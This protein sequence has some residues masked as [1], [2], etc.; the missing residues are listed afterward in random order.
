MLNAQGILI[1]NNH[2]LMV[3]Q[4][5]K[6]GDI[7]WTFPGGGIEAGETPEQACIRELRE[8]TGFTVK[9]LKSI[10][11]TQENYIFMAEILSGTLFLDRLNKDNEDIIEVEWVSL[12]D[13][14]KF[15][16]YIRPTILKLK[17]I[18]GLAK[19]GRRK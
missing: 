16:D 13:E 17:R 19:R 9:V 5:V 6:R 1:Q 3:K 18:L 2:I 7:V 14:D 12:N 11:I 4:Y 10:A 8:E 15:D